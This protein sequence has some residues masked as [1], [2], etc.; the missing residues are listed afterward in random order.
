LNVIKIF[1][2]DL[3]THG[4][5]A[6]VVSKITAFKNEQLRSFSRADGD[7]KVVVLAKD[8]PLSKTSVLGR[9]R[10]WFGGGECR[11]KGALVFWY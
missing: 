8:Q 1:G 3:C 7:G 9:F 6:L 2:R 4:S 10:Q 5:E 11:Q